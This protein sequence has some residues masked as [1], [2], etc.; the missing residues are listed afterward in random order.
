MAHCHKNMEDAANAD[1]LV[2]TNNNSKVKEFM[3]GGEDLNNLGAATTVDAAKLPPVD[4]IVVVF[5]FKMA[6]KNAC[7]DFE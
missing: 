3:F 7:W 1:I 6:T 5:A 4:Y 2:D